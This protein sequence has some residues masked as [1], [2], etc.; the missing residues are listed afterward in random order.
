VGE[1]LVAE[2]VIDAKIVSKDL[3]FVVRRFR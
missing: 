1:R 3:I 2:L